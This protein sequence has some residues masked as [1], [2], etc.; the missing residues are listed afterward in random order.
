MCLPYSSVAAAVPPALSSP[1]LQPLQMSCFIQI[2]VVPLCDNAREKAAELKEERANRD[3]RWDRKTSKCWCRGKTLVMEL[4]EDRRVS[5]REHIDLSLDQFLPSV[6]SST[7]LSLPHV[8]QALSEPL[9]IHIII[10]FSSSVYSSSF[11]YPLFSSAH[12]LIPSFLFLKPLPFAAIR[13]GSFFLRPLPSS[14]APHFSPLLQTLPLLFKH[15]MQARA[16]APTA[17]LFPQCSAGT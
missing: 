6:S 3:K 13:V 8:F 11:F 10:C 2:N 4:Y 17:A 16:T 12:L 14:P 5:S 15:M 9:S 7:P 1:V